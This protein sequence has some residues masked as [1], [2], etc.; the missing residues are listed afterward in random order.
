MPCVYLNSYTFSAPPELLTVSLNNTNITNNT[1]KSTKTTTTT[2]TTTT[3]V[4]LG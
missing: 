3:P 1:T 2:T 4:S